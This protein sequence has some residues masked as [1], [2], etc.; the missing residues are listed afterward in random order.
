MSTFLEK[1]THNTHVIFVAIKV[2]YRTDARYLL[3][4]ASSMVL[5]AAIPFADIYLLRGVLNQICEGGSTGGALTV[6]VFFSAL[7]LFLMA[8]R[9]FVMWYRSIHYI[10][11]GHRYDVRSARA[12]IH[13]DYQ[14]L[15]DEKTLDMTVRAGRACSAIARIGEH[16]SDIL[17][18]LAKIAGTLAILVPFCGW[19]VPVMAGVSVGCYRLDR[20]VESEKYNNEKKG[21]ASERKVDYFLKNILDTRTAKELRMFRAFGLF[22]QK[23]SSAEEELSALARST[24]RISL[25]GQA[26]NVAVS[27]GEIFAVYWIASSRYLGGAMAIG[28]ISLCVS[29]VMVFTAAMSA[30]FHKFA[31][32]GLLGQR[33]SD[34]EE[35]QKLC[36]GQ[37][38]AGE[39]PD[40][41]GR[42]QAEAAKPGFQGE[43]LAPSAALLEFKD[44]CYS[45][46]GSEREI[47]HNI[48][49]TVKEGERLAIV[50]ENGAGKST[51]IMLLLRLYTPTKGQILFRGADYRLYDIREYYRMFSTVFQDY[52]MFAY[53][54]REN[55]MFDGQASSENMARLR[56]VV[57]QLG[58]SGR[59]EGLNNGY[60]T[61]ITQNY[62][63]SGVSLS[64][65]ES[66]RVA[67]ARAWYRDAGIL[68]MDEPTSA[69]DPL[70][71]ER[72]FNRMEEMMSGKTVLLISHRL[73]SVRLCDKVAFFMDGRLSEFGTHEQLMSDGGDY[74][75]MYQAQAQWYA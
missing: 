3:L 70:S 73:S 7:S 19:F 9:V 48:S 47:L 15:Q 75:R 2:I 59:I 49:L 12:T 54:L 52:M 21:E 25:L 30:L 16:A 34:F 50:G 5:A 4:L 44:V 10:R 57:D 63:M 61:F 33:V 71:E 42:Q 41:T 18:E 14:R 27:A 29:S 28:D 64:G 38:G 53:T 55:I 43:A 20:Y 58:L 11:F 23:Y 74:C 40:E 46:P 45:Y 22:L 67:I 37:D 69:I 13:M 32:V 56:E 36:A 60:E 39:V 31:A 51:F 8:L 68:V 65:G 6:L 17:S 72:L 1:I 24:N 62:D 26:V 35:Y 66:Q